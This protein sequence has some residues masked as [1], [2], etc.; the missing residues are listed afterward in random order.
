MKRSVP[1]KTIMDFGDG[2]TFELNEWISE[3]GPVS[4]SSVLELTED[5]SLEELRT[6]EDPVDF[7]LHD[8]DFYNTVLDRKNRKKRAAG[9]FVATPV[10]QR[11]LSSTPPPLERHATVDHF[12]LPDDSEFGED[13]FANRFCMT[14]PPSTPT[15]PSWEDKLFKWESSPAYFAK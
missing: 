3:D 6:M 11:F 7:I 10:M 12:F 13:L 14:T 15:T 9:S 1:I 8:K 2:E 5:L 4:F